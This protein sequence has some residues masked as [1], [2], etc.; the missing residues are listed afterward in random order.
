MRGPFSEGDSAVSQVLVFLF[1]VLLIVTLVGHGIWVALAWFFR[2]MSDQPDITKEAAVEPCAWCDRATR[3]SRDRCEW[4]GRELHGPAARELADLTAMTRQLRRFQ[5]AGTLKTTVAGDLS[6]MMERRRHKL[7]GPAQQPATSVERSPFS[8]PAPRPEAKNPPSPT[9][10]IGEVIAAELVEKKPVLGPIPPPPLVSAGESI[11]KPAATSPAKP[12]TAPKPLPAT[13]KPAVPRPPAPVK[14]SRKPWTET[15]AEFMEER[16]IHSA[17]LIGVL[18]GGLLIV[19]S[20][21]ALV[22]SFWGD[23]AQRPWLKLAIFVGFSSVVFVVGLYSHHRWKLEYTGRRVLIIATL[24][25]PLNFL[26]TASFSKGEL[27]PWTMIAELAALGLFAFLVGLAARVLVPDGVKGLVLAVVGNSAAIVLFAV[28][29]GIPATTGPFLAMGSVPVAVF[30][31][32]IGGYL[33]LLSKRDKLDADG[34]RAVCTL[35]GTATFSLAVALGVLVDRGV[36]DNGMAAT[37]RMFSILATLAALPV[38]ATG[39]TVMRQTSDSIKHAMWRTAGTAVAIIG[40]MVMLAALGLAWPQPAAVIA[41][42]A[43][44]AVALAAVAF[45]YR[46]PIAQAAAIACASVAYLT[47]FHVCR[48]VLSLAGDGISS[49]DM[50]RLAVSAPSGAALTGLCLILGGI[51]VMLV[52]RGHRDHAEQYLGGCG[53]VAVISVLIVTWAGLFSESPEPML[54]MAVWAIYGVGSLVLN[55]RFQKMTLGYVGLVLLVGATL[56]ALEWLTPGV[57][58]SWAMVLSIEALLTAVAAAV[59]HRATDREPHAAWNS[60]GRRSERNSLIDGYRVPLAHLAEGL[61]CAALVLA[62]WTL[63]PLGRLTESSPFPVV[64]AICAAASYFLLAWGYRS[65]ERTWVGSLIVMAGLVHALWCNYVG[66]CTQDLM[67]A[68]LAHATAAVA[69]AMFLDFRGERRWG[70]EL[71]DTI[72]TVIVTPLGHSAVLSSTI[73]L[74]IMMFDSWSHTPTLA[75]CLFWLAAI[76]AVVAWTSRSAGL[77]AAC[78]AVVTLGTIVAV[79]AWLEHCRWYTNGSIRLGDP[80]CLEAYAVGLAIISLA[81]VLVRIVFRQNTVVRELLDPVFPAVDRIVAYGAIVGQLAVTAAFILPGSAEELVA[82]VQGTASRQL[83]LDACGPAGWLVVGLLTAMLIASLWSRWGKAE[84]L[85]CLLVAA[86]AGCLIAG[87][88]AVNTDTASALRWT[89]ATCFVVCS[90]AFWQR[91]RLAVWC[92]KAGATVEIGSDGQHVGRALLLSVTAG[93]VLAITVAV[94]LLQIMGTTSGGPG[95]NS[96]FYKLGAG[97]ELSYLVPLL[98]VIVGFVGH[99]IRESSAGY[100][101]SG[102]LIAK[103]SVVLGYLLMITRFG[104]TEFV[105]VV[106][107]VAVTSAV[108]AVGWIAARKWVDVWREKSPTDLESR[109]MNLQLAIGGLGNGLVLAPAMLGMIF[110]YPHL[111]DLTVA[112]GSWLGWAALLSVMGAAIYRRTDSHQQIRP[113]LAGLVGMA[114]LGLMAATIGGLTEPEWGYRILM[115]SMGMYAVAVASATW[116]VASLRALPD[117]QGPP[118]A[119]I[120]AAN[121]WV[122]TALAAA[123]MLGLKAAFWHEIPEDRLW[124]AAAIGLGSMAGAVMAVWRRQEGW[125]FLTAPGVNLAASLV[126]WYYQRQLGFDE[127]WILLVQANIIAGSAVAL[128]WAAALKRLGELRES[129]VHDSPLLGIQT[130]IWAVANLIV[131]FPAMAAI[132]TRPESLPGWCGQVCQPP[133]WIALLMSLAAVGWYLRQVS[134]GDMCHALGSLGWG[135]VILL[136]CWAESWGALAEWD[137]WLSYHVLITGWAAAGLALLGAGWLGRNLRLLRQADADYAVAVFPERH[138]ENWVALLGVLAVGASLYWCL[139]DQPG[140]P[141]WAMGAVL[142]VSLAAGL[143]AVWR[144]AVVCLAASII[145]IDV[146]NTI[147]WISW[148]DS[149]MIGIIEANVF[150]LA[151]ASIVWSLVEPMVKVGVPVPKLAGRP[152]PLAHL[153]MLASL[154]LMT[155][156]VAAYVVFDLTGVA[157]SPLTW[158]AWM[159]LGTLG[160]ACGCGLYDSRARFT[161]E[162]FYLLG[163][164]AVGTCLVYCTLM[165]EEL[166]WFAAVG[167]AGLVTA[168]ASVGIIVHRGRD[169]ICRALR[170]PDGEDRWAAGWFS[171][172]QALVGGLVALLS[173]WIALDASTFDPIGQPGLGPLWGRL[174]GPF[175]AFALVGAALA[176]VGR[177]AKPWRAVWQYATLAMAVAAVAEL[178]W[179]CLLQDDANALHQCVVLMVACVAGTLAVGPGL[180]RILSPDNDWTRRGLQV[181]PGLAGLALLM[182]LAVLVQEGMMFEPQIGAPVAT[183]AVVVVTAALA[184]LIFASLSFAVV[185]DWDPLKMSDRGRT[186]YVYAAEVLGALIGLHIWLCRPELFQLGIVEKYWMLIVMGVA[187][188]GAALSELFQR[189][190]LPVLSEPLGNTAVLLPLAPAIGFWIPTDLVPTSGLVGAT[191]ALWF[192]SGLFYGVLAVTRRSG[193]FA[194][195]AVLAAN[196]GL[197]VIWNRCELDFLDH[198]QLWLIPI[199]LACLIA[200]HLNRNRLDGKQSA[201]IRYFA[202]GMIYVSSTVEFLRAIGDSVWLPLVLIGLSVIGIM[203]GVV[204]RIRSFV[205]MGFSFL[206]LVI[207]SLIWYAGVDQENTWILWVFCICVGVAIIGFFAVFEKYRSEISAGIRRFRSWVG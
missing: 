140:G 198:P 191:P 87:R 203:A 194:A 21:A 179:A 139:V 79:T 135:L 151:I 6:A 188:G 12:S 67:V 110:W 113:Q 94:A 202:L 99:A 176:M 125:A 123:V 74:P 143:L 46:F 118:Q 65:A 44:N 185:A 201:A 186:A 162:A 190:G 72:R 105:T 15:L 158:Q 62:V 49:G 88:F 43:F 168:A 142:G 153:A 163:L 189:R 51:A 30:A 92:K 38:L 58:V 35:L 82:G 171:S 61:T 71:A 114:V 146:A 68:L 196:T 18:L 187:F 156:F 2:Q 97:L 165:P 4:C 160:V 128:V 167:L 63:W 13:P 127:W 20:S 101:F 130:T 37:L 169:G 184:G 17:E 195:L 53:V 14:P 78:Q 39:L 103:L 157:R 147:G 96:I 108:W 90:A 16:N 121:V 95:P 45:H 129:S 126:V 112:A 98:L 117:G 115:L 55:A 155:V 54:A 102:G 76:W 131:L 5:T 69:A 193:W 83:Q 85:G 137:P 7:I 107:L 31:G 161:L 116:W 152:M 109:L 28:V 183:W 36:D 164:T 192:L 9:I 106:Q 136:A 207:L 89:L 91:D 173:V 22:S 111:P 64:T 66:L 104:T 19:G 159:L 81:W 204:L 174:A 150:G 124:A 119:L 172:T 33:Y 34:A 52:R 11:Q 86:T 48:G 8:T 77:F 84:L 75:A 205:Y 26:A 206:S 120:R 180:M 25:V 122:S 56:W 134:P 166:G 93:P 182:L 199:A 42:G 3:R 200:E 23:L 40:M 181:V 100:A 1:I 149:A 132:M 70:K 138:V 145:L 133:G 41:V 178:G 60:A 197:W 73:V 50:L 24:L 175:A 144:R 59:L 177:C 154:V 47:G 29:A 32:A 170:I 80:R 57:D 141:W 10:E 148:I 27:D